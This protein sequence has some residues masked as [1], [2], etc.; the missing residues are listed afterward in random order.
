[1]EDL[2]PKEIFEKVVE[3]G[4]SKVNLKI[5]KMF[6][7]S[8]LAGIYNSIGG[9]LYTMI[10]QDIKIGTG[11]S[12]FFGGSAFSVGLMLVVLT[13]AELFTGNNLIIISLLKRR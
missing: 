1:M 3:I 13:G 2:K 11:F 6:I 5:Y 4:K 7:L 8:L 12:Q 9:E 10:T